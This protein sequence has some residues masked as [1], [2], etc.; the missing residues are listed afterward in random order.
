MQTKI[1]R[2]T[3]IILILLNCSLIFYFSNQE[4]VSSSMQS[5]R[6]I[7]IILNIIPYTRNI[8]E[9]QKNNLIEM[10][11]PII[12]KMAHLFIYALLGCFTICFMNTFENTNKRKRIINTLLFCF[13]YAS[14]DEV[15][16]IFIEGRS[17]TF[18]DVLIDTLGA[19]LGIIFII[20]GS[21][22]MRKLRER[23]S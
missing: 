3:F 12:R 9:L 20:I 14:T 1:K 10:L 18:R 15:H 5:S 16:Q 13:I 7:E 11:T 22:I 19:S 23:K 4:T 17:G 6:T 8:E 2:I 21:T